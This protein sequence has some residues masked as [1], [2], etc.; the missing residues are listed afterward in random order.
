MDPT[1]QPVPESQGTIPTLSSAHNSDEIVESDPSASSSA[2][3]SGG[4]LGDLEAFTL[5]MSEAELESIFRSCSH[6]DWSKEVDLG[7]T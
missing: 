1:R 3:R 2:P 5:P 4:G 6:V 7:F